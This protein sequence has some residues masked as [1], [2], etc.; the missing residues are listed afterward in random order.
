MVDDYTLQGL[1]IFILSALIILKNKILKNLIKAINKKLSDYLLEKIMVVFSLFKRKYFRELANEYRTLH[2]EG[3]GKYG[4][5][6]IPMEDIY[7][8]LF[9]YEQ[10]PKEICYNL[11]NQSETNKQITIWDIIERKNDN[12]SN[13]ILVGSPGSGKS[14]LLRHIVF[15]TTKRRKKSHQIRVLR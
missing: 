13:Y 4:S 7:I 5:S 3:L 15:E 12:C 14:T 1:L 9:V 2:I 8:E 11:I 6:M 10:H